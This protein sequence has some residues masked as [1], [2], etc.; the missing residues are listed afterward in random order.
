MV[1]HRVLDPLVL[2]SI[3]RSV[4]VPTRGK[5][6][7][8]AAGSVEF[9][10]LVGVRSFNVHAFSYLLLPIPGPLLNTRRVPLFKRASRVNVNFCGSGFFVVR[11]FGCDSA[12]SRG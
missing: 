2:S 11:F 10:G 7:P 1:E 3:P 5:S 6:N 12:L 8:V 9:C 4:S